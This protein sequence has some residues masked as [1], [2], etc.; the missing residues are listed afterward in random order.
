ML[1]EKQTGITKVPEYRGKHENYEIVFITQKITGIA[2]IGL[3]I[4]CRDSLY[5]LG[6][7]PYQ[8]LK[9]L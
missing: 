4:Y 6:D 2:I 9:A 1:V 8:R 3:K 5:S 7:W